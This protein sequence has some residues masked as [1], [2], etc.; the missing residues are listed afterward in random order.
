[1]AQLDPVD[2]LAYCVQEFSGVANHLAAAMLE[3][4]HTGKIP[5]SLFGDQA[6]N[7]TV[8]SGTA[9]PAKPAAK[10]A[11]P[12]ADKKP[13]QLTA[14]NWYVKAQIA[15]LKK[16]GTTETTAEGKPVNLMTMAGARWKELGAEG[17]A[18]F[19]KKFKVCTSFRS[20]SI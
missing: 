1:M 10:K 2:L 9:K 20:L 12:A 11:K 18:E 15:E 16:N 4:Q 5:E 19:T 8:A 14:F 13:R 17:Q 3:A 7:G 6:Q